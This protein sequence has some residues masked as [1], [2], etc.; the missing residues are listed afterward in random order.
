VVKGAT[1]DAATGTFTVPA[2]TTAVFVEPSA[3][4]HH[5]GQVDV[6][7]GDQ[8]VVNPRSRGML[9]VAVLSQPGFD[10][11]ADVDVDSLR[12]GVTGEED[13]VVRCR[14]ATT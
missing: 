14:R 8:P 13:S 2:R 4:A 11:V 9:P 6:R 7:P 12:F 1:F 5:R 3:P 10:P